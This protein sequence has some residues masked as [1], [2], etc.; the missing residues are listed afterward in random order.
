MTMS[1]I[2]L[3]HNCFAGKAPGFAK[4]FFVSKDYKPVFDNALDIAATNKKGGPAIVKD[5]QDSIYSINTKLNEILYGRLTKKINKLTHEGSLDK[6]DIADLLGK[7]EMPSDVRSY[8]SND[9]KN[10]NGRINNPGLTEFLDGLSFPFLA[11][12]LILAANF[13]SSRVMYNDRP[14]LQ[15]F[16]KQIGRLEHP[17]KMLWL[18]DTFEDNNGVSMVLKAMHQEI[19]E[20]DLPIDILVCSNNLENDDHLIVMKPLAEFSL[21]FYKQQPV[22]IPNFMDVHKIFQVG[23]YDRIICS[24]EGIMG[25]AAIYLK[26]AF[27]IKAHFFIHTDWIVFVKKVLNIDRPNLNRFRRLLRAYYKAFDSLFVLNNDQQKWL[28]G[29]EM[30]FESSNVHLTAH[31]ADDCFSVRKSTKTEAFGVDENSPVILFAGR[32]SQEKGVMELPEIFTVVKK[33]IPDL[34]I[35]IAGAGPAEKNIRSA[36]PEA[37]FLGWIDH[38]DLPAI[39]SAAD[40]LILP[41]KFDTFSCVVLESL[42]CGLPVIAYKSKGPKDIIQNENCGYVV[43]SKSEMCEK[44]ITFFEDPRQQK[45]F[46]KMALKRAKD[47]DKDKIM[48]QFLNDLEFGI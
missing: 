43:S 29:R 31:W 11:S 9:K 22:R 16:S 4:R 21:P 32:L 2:E 33:H 23:G 42:S 18:T 40:L 1:F 25:L 19:K 47:Y 12:S 48:E 44:I 26:N 3:F 39:Y 17:K 27:S 13:T 36:L 20:K 38:A 45:S 24:T 10:R 34:R 8:I 5:Y 7:L 35:V 28:T 15:E 6:L 41:S 30:G 14:L 37:I 46:R